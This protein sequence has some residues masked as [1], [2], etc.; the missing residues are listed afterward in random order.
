[1]RSARS[2]NPLPGSPLN[3]LSPTFAPS[4]S[5]RIT[6]QP[7]PAS[8]GEVAARR[9]LPPASTF[10]YLIALVHMVP[11]TDVPDLDWESCWCSLTFELA[12]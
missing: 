5:V 12:P 7:R 9:L 4:A 3:P 10:L 8:A 1:M 11:L 2:N 6:A